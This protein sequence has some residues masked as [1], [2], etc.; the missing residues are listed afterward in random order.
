[1]PDQAM[2]GLWPSITFDAAVDQPPAVFA[3][4]QRELEQLTGSLLTLRVVSRPH[5]GQVLHD[6]DIDARRIAYRYP[7]FQAASALEQSYPVKVAAEAFPTA[8]VADDPDALRGVLRELFADP[9]VVSVVKHLRS[10][11]TGMA[12]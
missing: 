5:L 3:Q 7:L 12:P 8:R 10:L 11:S 9:K 1:M 6:V 2:T 4:A